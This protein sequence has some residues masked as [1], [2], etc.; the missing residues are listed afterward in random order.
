[1]PNAYSPLS[2]AFEHPKSSVPPAQA[3]PLSAGSAIAASKVPFVSRLFIVNLPLWSWI[4]LGL[5]KSRN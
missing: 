3:A 4:A 1:M 5:L 2:V